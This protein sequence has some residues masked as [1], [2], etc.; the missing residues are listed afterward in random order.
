MKKRLLSYIFGGIAAFVGICM[1]LLSVIF[2]FVV[3]EKDSS[4]SGTVSTDTEI[5]NTAV[6]GDSQVTSLVNS[7]TNDDINTDSTGNVYYVDAVNG[8]DNNNGQS[9]EK[10]FRSLYRA[11]SLDLKPGDRLLFKRDCVWNGELVIDDSGTADHP[12]VI[13]MYGEGEKPLINGCGEVAA[14]VLLRDVSFVTVRNLEVT[15]YTEET[16]DYRTCISLL[17]RDA[18]VE[19]VH[20]ENNYVHSQQSLYKK[21]TG[22]SVG[23]HGFGGINMMR[24]DGIAWDYKTVYA[25]NIFIENNRVDRV[26]GT[27]IGSYVGS[28]NIQ[29]RNNIVSNVTG[30]GIII[31]HTFDSLVEHNIV[32]TSGFGGI[33]NPHVNIWSYVATDTV[34]QYNESYDCQS[35]VQDGQGFDIDDACVRCTVQ[36]NYSHDNVGGFFLGCAYYNE[37][38]GNVVRYNISQNDKKRSF[39]MTCPSSVN[40]KYDPDKPMY[41]VYNNTV[42]C[43][44]PLDDIIYNDLYTAKFQKYGKFHNNIFYCIGSENSDWGESDMA[45][46]FSDNC[47]YGVDTSMITDDNKIT[48]NPLLLAAGTGRVGM[49]TVDGYKLLR[50]SPLLNA[51]RL[52][53]DNGG[54]DYWGNPVSAY[55]NPN[56]GAYQGDGVTRP[57]ALN[58]TAGKI[59]S[60]SFYD[61]LYGKLLQNLTDEKVSTV[62]QSKQRNKNTEEYIEIAFD[63]KLSLACVWLTAAADSICFPQEY[64]LQVKKDGKWVTVADSNDVKS[65]NGGETLTFNF[66][67][68]ETDSLRISITKL[69]KKDGKYFAELAEISAF[70][71]PITME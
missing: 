40:L 28:E 61:S 56:I 21:D 22:R 4:V 70:G 67:K 66:D 57:E 14:T 48:E 20:I 54:K 71:I 33:G 23:F 62:L 34:M 38:Y 41:E 26:K 59:A 16:D 65:P 13:G 52:I 1:I 31:G 17:I 51:G 12:I 9:K 68:V 49:N 63:E 30:D 32:Y 37:Y 15:N 5:V 53:S 2:D 46:E 29:I 60:T 27:G 19:G 6:E 10:A 36:Y 50:N 25:K 55:K 44:V 3:P 69:A 64:E 24:E 42:F 47:Y 35:S 39:F 18:S 8:N 58:L 45:F 11:T 7:M 43:N